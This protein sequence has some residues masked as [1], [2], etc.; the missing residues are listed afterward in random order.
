MNAR[1]HGDDQCKIT[2]DHMQWIFTRDYT[3][4]P[5]YMVEI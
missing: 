3:T 2:I 1:D 4:L 5:L